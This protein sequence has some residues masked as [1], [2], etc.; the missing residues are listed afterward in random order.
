[1]RFR[2]RPSRVSGRLRASPSKSY[3]HR[4]ILLAALSGGPARVR[5]GLVAEDTEATLAGVA[6]LGARVV[7]EE[8]ALTITSDGFRPA[9]GEIDARNSGTTLRL[10]AGVAASLDGPTVLTGDASLRKRPMGPLLD[11]LRTL[12]ARG[13]SLRG[14]GCAPVQVSGPLAG[15]AVSIEGSVSSQFVSSLL[16]AASLA[17]GPTTVRV[18]PPI[19]SEPYV[20]VTVHMLARFG[21]AVHEDGNR[22]HVEAGQTYRPVNVDVPGD[23]SSA[24][25]PLVAAAITDG[26]VAVEG[27]D[28][29]VPPGDRRVG[30]LLRTFGAHIEASGD[31]VRVRGG[32]LHA[33]TVD[34]G[35][36]PDLFPVLAVLAT[37]ADGES[38]FVNGEHLRVKESDR[39]A[40]TV[41]SLRAMG[42]SVEATSDGCIVRGPSR[43]REAFVA[44]QGDHRILMAAAVA[45]LVAE[46]PVDISD[47]MCFRVSYPGFLED[48]RALGASMEVVP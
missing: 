39:I 34:I 6:A 29:D 33:R 5:R 46:G 25:F 1:M 14:D 4:A 21:V 13:L 43:L 45:G 20:D 31:T 11:A 40:T 42:A 27:L 3:T 22:Y 18:L 17:R 2:S 24:A 28:P 9:A 30:D 16:V 10:L 44:S 12:G 19:R 37:Q 15:G 7:R 26:D 36:T 41:A 48:M 38:R 23:F 47:P 32:P 35:D 8:D